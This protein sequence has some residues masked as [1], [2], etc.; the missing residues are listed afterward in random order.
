VRLSTSRHGFPDTLE[1][2]QSGRFWLARIIDQTDR[3][4]KV[5][6]PSILARRSRRLVV[7]ASHE[8]LAHGFGALL[9][10]ERQP[11]RLGPLLEDPAPG[12]RI[13]QAIRKLE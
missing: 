4:S 8:R 3:S 13:G 1:L 6:S 2:S 9:G 11:A 12:K 5:A 7:D 10:P